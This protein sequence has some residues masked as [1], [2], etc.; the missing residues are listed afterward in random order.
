MENETT[1]F[2]WLNRGFWLA[3]AT[4][5]YLILVV[6]RDAWGLPYMLYNDQTLSAPIKSF[7]MQGQIVCAVEIALSFAIYIALVFLMH[8]LIGAVAKGDM[9]LVKA[10]KTMGLLGYMLVGFSFF[11]MLVNIPAQYILNQLGDLKHFEP[12]FLVDGLA[13]AGGLTFFAL[14]A[15]IR[16][17]IL[18]QEDIDLTI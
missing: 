14:R 13:L 1:L 8:R 10:L 7:S 4:L 11:C 18:M 6:C 12:K 5:A 15:I 3:W 2:K 17:A 9:L 16:R